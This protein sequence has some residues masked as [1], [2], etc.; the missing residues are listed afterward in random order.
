V[1][2][3]LLIQAGQHMTDENVDNNEAVAAIVSDAMTIFGWCEGQAA[4]EAVRVC[5]A[6]PTKPVIVQVGIFMGR[7]TA[8]LAGTCRVRAD[9]RVYCVDPLDG[10]GDSFSV[11]YYTRELLNSGYP[12]LE[13]AFIANMRRLRLQE[14]IE[15]DK[16]TGQAAAKSWSGPIDMLWLDADQ[17]P[18][19]AREIFE[20]WVPFL[21]TGGTLVL[22]NT[23]D[24]S[25]APGHDG[26]RRLVQEA[27]HPPMFDSIRQIDATTFA[28]RAS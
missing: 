27:I 15:L 5:L 2:G 1:S 20:A 6:L 18:T 26:N 24:R 28:V 8:L 14:W 12:S 9:A 11:P 3:L 22:R 7:S 25:Y 21:R 10:S 13:L 23:A 17:S 19:A 16:V 4:D